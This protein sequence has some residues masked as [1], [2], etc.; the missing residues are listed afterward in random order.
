VPDRLEVTTNI[1]EQ[2]RYLIFWQLLNQSEEFLTL[3]A[4]KFSV[5]SAAQ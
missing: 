5:R 1:I 2:R 3:H 4:H